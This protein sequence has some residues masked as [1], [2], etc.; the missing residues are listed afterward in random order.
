[1][2]T[3]LSLWNNIE[4]KI[5]DLENIL[6]NYDIN[7]E[8]AYG[9]TKKQCVSEWIR[10]WD[11]TTANTKIYTHG[12]H[13]YPA[14][15]IPQ[16]IR[17]LI[18]EYTNEN[19]V[20]LDIFCGSGTTMV[21]CILTGRGSMGIEINPLAVLLA[22]VKTTPID[23]DH[24]LEA[25]KGIL[26]HFGNMDDFEIINFANIDIWF[27]EKT[28]LN[29]SKLIKSINTINNKELRNAFQ[30]CFSDIVRYVSTCKHSGFKMHRD[31]NKIDVE[32]SSEDILD[33]FHKSIE[34]L[35]LGMAQFNKHIKNYQ[36]PIIVLGN[37]CEVQ[38]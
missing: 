12:I 5:L 14:M 16:V 30:I 22:K 31:K 3:Q 33:E 1:M 8:N 36:A 15:F 19:D 10:E 25:Y 2:R 23:I 27:T 32:W 38:K 18:K 37:S 21:E 26:Y 24:F 20:V 17:K 13:Q 35:I 6:K 11:F 4:A 34:C 9:N 28:K 7:P 29:L